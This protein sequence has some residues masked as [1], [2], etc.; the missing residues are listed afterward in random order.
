MCGIIA[1]LRR[2]PSRDVPTAE[3][4]LTLLVDATALLGVPGAFLPNAAVEGPFDAE[5]V[6]P[7]MSG[8]DLC[9]MPE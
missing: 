9:R 5:A 3:S 4:I 6:M 2:P 8:L 1:I 7:G